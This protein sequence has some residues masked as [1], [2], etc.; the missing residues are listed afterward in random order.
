VRKIVR[1]ICRVLFVVVRNWPPSYFKPFPFG[2][3]LRNWL[4]RGILDE[5]G[6][7]VNVERGARF[8]NGT[9]IRL[10]NYSGIGIGAEVNS[11]TTIG[12]YVM[13]APEVVILTQNHVHDDV[14][15]PMALQGHE[16]FKPVVI[17]D[18]V[19]LGQRAMIMPGVVIGKGS[20][21]G[22][23]AV[24]AK[25]VPPY[26]IAVGNPARVVRSRLPDENPP[27]N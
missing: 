6:K 4:A 19:W 25:S 16:G 9:G 21:I 27:A 7:C 20:I 12:N 8:G 26:S 10:G 13:M 24:V 1:I 23:G 5:C 22:A 11:H 14:S 15:T 18:D 17:E 2:G 3:Y